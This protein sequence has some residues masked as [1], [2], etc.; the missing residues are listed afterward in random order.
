VDD[1]QAR[2]VGGRNTFYGEVPWQVLLKESKLF[3]LVT[4][5]K[6]GGALI[7]DKWLVTAAHCQAGLFGSLDVLI[8]GYN[9]GSNDSNS[10]AIRSKRVIM[11]PKFNR[12]TFDNDI[13]LIELDDRVK[14]D[15]Y[16]QP[17]CLPDKGDQFVPG[18]IASVSGWGYTSYRK[19]KFLSK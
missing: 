6:C 9:L 4:Y 8:G 16:V 10:R 1:L 17:I 13:A 2:I 11:H 5:R 14:F 7:S 15:D 3:G 19:F 18:T 12:F